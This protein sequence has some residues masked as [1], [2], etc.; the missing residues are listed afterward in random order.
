M[1]NRT[2][3]SLIYCNTISKKY[4]LN[5]QFSG[6]FLTYIKQIIGYVKVQERFN[7]CQQNF[8]NLYGKDGQRVEGKAHKWKY[9]KLLDA[10][11]DDRYFQKIHIAR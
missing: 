10:I 11:P 6:K 9:F 2:M 7:Y 1:A 5:N 8:L 4:N 3:H